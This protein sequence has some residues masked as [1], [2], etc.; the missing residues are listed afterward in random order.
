MKD[1]K[2]LLKECRE[3]IKNKDYDL[4]FKLSKLI[5][6][7]DRDN[8]MGLIFL[9]LSLQEVG[10]SEQAV[11][12]FRKAIQ[13]D[14]SNPLAWNGVINY[15][16]KF[17]DDES[18]KHLVQSYI[19]ILNAESNTKKVLEYCEKLKNTQNHGDALE[20]IK[21]LYKCACKFEENYRIYENLIE[22]YTNLQKTSNEVSD[23]V[24]LIV[25]TCFK[26]LMS[27]PNNLDI[28]ICSSYLN[29]LYK[30][31]KY[32][33]VM[34][35]AE[36][37]NNRFNSST[38]FIIW[39]CKIYN[40]IHLEDPNL[41]EQYSTL[42]EKYS[43]HL[44]EKDPKD[45][46]GLFTKSIY[47][48]KDNKVIEARELLV[49]VCVSRPG[50][51]HAWVY[52]TRLCVDL[53]LFE[54][55]LQAYSS[56]EKL[57]KSVNNERLK[58][59][60]D[61]L[62][63]KLLSYSTSKEDWLKVIEIYDDIGDHAMK[64]SSMKYVILAKI[65]LG[66]LDEAKLLISELKK[67]D[68]ELSILLLAKLFQ[69]E[70][71]FQDALNLL[72]ENR[73]ESWESWLLIGQL[74][75]NLEYYSKCLAPFL[76]ATKLNPNQ[77]ICFLHLGSYYEKVDDLDKARRCYEKAFKINSKSAEVGIELSKVYCKQKNYM[78]CQN[79][80]KSLATDLI[81]KKNSWAWL[82]LG[83]SYLEQEEYS[84]AIEN[85]RCVVR[86]EKEN[87]HCW[88][89]LADAYFARG[90][91]TSAL[92][93]YE[94]SLELATNSLYSSLQIANIKKT[95]GYHSEA[96]T[97]FQEILLKNK[98]YV[99]ALKGLAET[100][101]YLAQECYRNQRLGT[102]RDHVQSALDNLSQ[103]VQQRS[104]FSC[105]WKL[106]ADVC[107][108]VA[109]LP[110]KY[111]CLFVSPPLVESKSLFEKEELFN[112]STSCYCKAIGYLDNNILLWHDLANCY[113]AHAL[114]TENDEK[115][116]LL[117]SY[118]VAAAEHCT[119]D[120]PS[121]WQHWNLLG[122][123]ALQRRPP[124]YAL[125]QHYFIKAV[126]VDHNSAIA[127]ANL[128]TIYLIL[129]ELKLANKAFAQGQRADPNYVNSWIG[130]AM[131][132]ESMDRDEAMDLFRHSVQLGQNQQGSIG[133][134]H[135]VCRTILS[136]S[137]NTHL[138]SIDDMHAVP[139]A[140]DALTWY[141][142]RN[143]EDGCAWNMLGMLRERMG[144][145]EGTLQ[146]YKSAYHFSPK[147]RDSARINYGRTLAK[148]GDLP[149]AIDVFQDVQEATFSSGSGLALALFQNKQYED[150][151]NAYEQALHWLAE[152]QTH[153]SEL[154]VA[155]ASMAYMFQGQE[156]AKALLYQSIGLKPRSPWSLYATMALG[157][158]HEDM[159]LAQ[160]VLKEMD[161]LKDD[162]ECQA[163]YA[164]L[165]SS[166]YL[167]TGDKV[168]AIKEVS[169]LIH[170][171]PDNSS[172]WMN[173]ALL[174]LRLEKPG[175]SAAKC[176]Q[177]A[178]NNIQANMDVTKML[179]YVSLAFMLVGDQKQA[180][181]AAQKA[182]HSY[183]H[184]AD[185]WTILVSVLVREKCSKI[186][187]SDLISHIETI[188]ASEQMLAWT[189][190]LVTAK[191]CDFI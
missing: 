56:A 178:L 77:Y 54:E 152:D 34:K 97:E 5:L 43:A 84:Q 19:G 143:T 175:L 162:K 50:L 38:I 168:G 33:D 117:L 49:Q 163:P 52:L 133:Y 138:Y 191:S 69:K 31:K 106:I 173:L 27:S 127:W 87:T 21:V 16:E 59:I 190:S 151:Y 184:V 113:L 130:Q 153:Q 126:M 114:T 81:N 160:L 118:C 88:Q 89:S 107:L 93:C 119:A 76:K 64:E 20:I 169:K 18:K 79:L 155:L 67:V 150:S 144:L 35:Q 161:T 17:D 6:K 112:L 116:E 172:I 47:L 65:H 124:N 177:V 132:A 14:E 189:R 148:L 123:I 121:N 83:L 73:S 166:M 122:N 2:V 181:V 41:A 82:Q 135:W 176:A 158:L 92:K 101:I 10:P 85:L 125:A 156:A 164:E 131:I 102:A 182:V 115:R 63:M 75:W 134:A 129:G 140:C 142:R 39:I 9:G 7:E 15:Y 157:L 11:K 70:T 57:M 22:V 120:N 8:Y 4:S 137:P 95:L 68:H 109:K 187:I 94:K 180:L 165:L 36:F 51:I 44:L 66:K 30:Q 90:S 159:E 188:G 58:Q 74:Y 99:P 149:A 72:E 171:H 25:E 23:E 108:F 32:T 60:L 12:A 167:L 24:L 26:E 170:R 98:Q 105:L 1:V 48:V 174:L 147:H 186:D 185:T 136:V 104:S 37:I 29:F 78:A 80:L 28:H 86:I 96:K 145:R 100:F 71:C 91:F 13:H 103:A 128:G 45:A 154:L 183:P 42:V 146:A 110:E 53:Q 141:T 61:V 139:V 3:A 179:G 46:I 62:H 40:Q 111:C 55:G